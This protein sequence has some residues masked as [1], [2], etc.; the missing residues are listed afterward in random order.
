[1]K[2]MHTILSAAMFGALVT[3]ASFAQTANTATSGTTQTPAATTQDKKADHRAE[4]REHHEE[5]ME[6]LGL[7]DDQKA[8]MKALHQDGKKQAEAIKADTTLTPEQK[9]EKMKTLHQDMM[10]K[11][12][13]ILTPEQKKKVDEMKAAHKGKGGRHGHRRHQ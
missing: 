1:M 5:M 7:T 12:D 9:K 11:R 4:M 2:V 6:K 8:Q 13:A 10:T 3:G